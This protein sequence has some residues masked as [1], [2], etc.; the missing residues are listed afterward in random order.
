MSGPSPASP[1]G[2][3]GATR[4]RFDEG[5][6]HDALEFGEDYLGLC[7]RRPGSVEHIEALIL[8]GVVHGRL[9]DQEHRDEYVMRARN[10]DSQRTDSLLAVLESEE[11]SDSELDSVQVVL[12]ED[13]SDPDAT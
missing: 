3:Q 6:Y 10:I 4:Y 11:V 13:D 5:A 1:R 2:S 8:V 12:P 7:E 9:G